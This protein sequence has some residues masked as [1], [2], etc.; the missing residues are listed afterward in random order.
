MERG[1]NIVIIY[2]LPIGPDIQSVL[3][4]S[5][6]IALIHI[7]TK[8]P[9]LEMHYLCGRFPFEQNKHLQSVYKYQPANMIMVTKMLLTH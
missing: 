3:L 8:M 5:N 1:T 2:S 4:I 9:H 7:S 6:M